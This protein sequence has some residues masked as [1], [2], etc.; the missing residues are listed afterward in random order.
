MGQSV[1]VREKAR[2][3]LLGAEHLELP[4][5]RLAWSRIGE[6]GPPRGCETGS[7]QE[8]KLTAREEWTDTSFRM[9]KEEREPFVSAQT[10][11]QE[12]W[13]LDLGV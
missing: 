8:W 4:G 13:Q 11:C 5:R 2:R 6:R 10:E 12:G 1:R 3:R 9:G 7:G